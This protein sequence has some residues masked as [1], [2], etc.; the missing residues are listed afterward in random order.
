MSIQSVDNFRCLLKCK[1]NSN[2]QSVT[3]KDNNCSLYANFP[4]K[5][6]FVYS[7]GFSLYIKV[8]RSENFNGE[9]I[10][11]KNKLNNI[12]YDEIRTNS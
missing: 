5:Q 1:M 7:P 6:F 2:C 11:L 10:E 8:K 3:F 9:L 4:S 12:L